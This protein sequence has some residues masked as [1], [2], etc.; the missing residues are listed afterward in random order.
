MKSWTLIASY[1]WKD[2]WSRWLEQPSSVL[3]R[4]FV[5]SLLVTVATVILVAFNLLERN[6]RARLESFG[7]NTI[8]TRE[9][10]VATE[11]L[12]MP[13]QPRPDLY[14]P[15]KEFGDKIRLRQFFLRANTP[16]QKEITV[17]SYDDEALAML[18]DLIHPKTPLI[19]LSDSLPEGG[20]VE[21]NLDRH[22]YT[23]VVRRPNTFF[24]PL[25]SESVLLLPQGWSPDAERIGYFETTLFRRN[26]DTL[27]ILHFVTAIQHLFTAENRNP[28]QIQSA[29][30]MVKDL[31]N[32]QARQAQWRSAMAG[33][34]GLAVALVFGAIAVLEFR[35]NAY[36]SA[37]LRSFGAPGKALYIRQWIENGVLA[38]L[39]AISAIVVLACFHRELFGLLGFPRDLLDLNKANP[40]ISWE[41]ALILLWVNIGAFLSSLSVALG[42]RKPVGEILS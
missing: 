5:G 24:R 28:P 8:V 15:L 32:L 37:L 13:N 33:L 40:Y 10:V 19:Y 11:P 23:A 20:L 29:L 18:G 38:N 9:M 34:L 16:W 26:P 31:E 30:G 14:A 21:M 39:A 35:Q 42:L 12:A 17:F 4:I 22:Q 25:A 27:P 36:V 41:I 7:V 6:L 1:L 3:S 2:T